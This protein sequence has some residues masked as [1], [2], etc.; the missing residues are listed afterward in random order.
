MLLDVKN[1]DG[2]NLP[3]TKIH[4]QVASTLT[5]SCNSQTQRCGQTEQLDVSHAKDPAFLRTQNVI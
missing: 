4:E 1:L 3:S 5:S 2:E